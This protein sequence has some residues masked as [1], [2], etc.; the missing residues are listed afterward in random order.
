MIYITDETR[1]FI[2]QAYADGV[3]CFLGTASGDGHP[4][5]SMKGSVLVF[6]RETLAYWERAKRSALDNVAANPNVVIFYRNPE[7]RINWRFHGTA[8]VYESGAI[9]DN[10]MQ[11]T[12]PAELDRDPERQGVAVLVRLDQVTELSGNVLQKRG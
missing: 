6:D 1:Q 12:I 4:Q 10:V 3:P 7:K 2:D 8:T 11:R 5:I 9:R